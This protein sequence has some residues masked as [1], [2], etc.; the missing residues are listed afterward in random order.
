MSFPG[1]PAPFIPVT[2]RG[3]RCMDS[4]TAP[5][6][7]GD[8]RKTQDMDFVGKYNIEQNIKRQNVAG[9]LRWADH[10]HLLTESGPASGRPP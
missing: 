1:D 3:Y 7:K 4:R 6:K 10:L 8:T 5:R 2:E 9:R